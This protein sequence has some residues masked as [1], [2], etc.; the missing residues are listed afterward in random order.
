MWLAGM[1]SLIFTDGG[2]A[3]FFIGGLE[4]V[5]MPNIGAGSLTGLD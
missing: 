3:Q 4:K 1:Y 2:V 5:F